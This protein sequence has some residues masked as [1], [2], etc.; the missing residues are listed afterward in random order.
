[1][2]GFFTD[3]GIVGMLEAKE[4]EAAETV[5]PF[6]GAPIETFCVALSVSPPNTS[7]TKLVHYIDFLIIRCKS[8]GWT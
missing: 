2:S 6:N 5:S 1:M 3:T 4:Y 8:S 7:L